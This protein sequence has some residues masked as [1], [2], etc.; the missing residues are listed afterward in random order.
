MLQ[1]QGDRLAL[2]TTHAS[3][4]VMHSAGWWKDGGMW[5]FL[6]AGTSSHGRS[7]LSVTPTVEAPGAA[8]LDLRILVIVARIDVLVALQSPQRSTGEPRK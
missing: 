3:P 2:S 1:W 6:P 8:D 4:T 7:S 5:G